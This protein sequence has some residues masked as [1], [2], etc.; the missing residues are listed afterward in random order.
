L[1]ELCITTLS[2]HY[3]LFGVPIRA[4][5]T[6]HLGGQIANCLIR[7]RRSAAGGEFLRFTEQAHG[8]VKKFMR[9]SEKGLSKGLLN[10]DVLKNLNYYDLTLSEYCNLEGHGDQPEVAGGP[11]HLPFFGHQLMSTPR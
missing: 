9:S 2:D 4:K 5:R 8:W 7:R 11:G 6:A 1:R 10:D 3:E